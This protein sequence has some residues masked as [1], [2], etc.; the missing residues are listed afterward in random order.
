MTDLTGMRY[1]YN[2]HKSYRDMDG[3]KKLFRLLPFSLKGIMINMSRQTEKALQELR[4]ILQENP[5]MA[6]DPQHIL[7][8]MNSRADQ[9]DAEPDAMD[10]LEMAENTVTK[11][12]ALEYI[13]KALAL[14]PGNL[15][16]LKLRAEISCNTPEKMEKE[17]L[18]L[19]DQAEKQLTEEGYFDEENIGEFWL[20]FETR[21]YMRLLNSLGDL[22][23]ES[24]KMRMAADI[25]NKML[26]LCTG[27]NLGVRYSLMHLFV[28]WED[29]PAAVSLFEKYP[30]DGTQF[31]LP[32]SMLYYKLNDYEKAQQYL[33]KL[34]KVNK[35]ARK[36]FRTVA[37]GK[38][39]S[40]MPDLSF[41]YRMNTI[42]ELMIEFQENS[43][44]ILTSAGFFQWA[45]ENIKTSRTSK[46]AQT[47]KSAKTTKSTS[48]ANAT[49]SSASRK[50][51]RS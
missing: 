2:R 25:Y 39:L 10:Y 9:E 33:I 19:V 24:G 4:K 20:I 21:P 22:Y 45:A 32:M 23:R 8:I 35:D 11:K 27:D 44:L 26:R 42:D 16:A 48:S 37:I 6:D 14:E 46:T 5:E 36:F 3:A 49:G 30:E 12:K 1:N 13:E 38:E 31:L 29:E 51:K 50:K 41:G 43:F 18:A 28:F 47:E 40:D 15:D 34:C 17:Y 7:Q